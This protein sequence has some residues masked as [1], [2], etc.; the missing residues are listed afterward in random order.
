MNRGLVMIDILSGESSPIGLS[1]YCVIIENLLML[2]QLLL[3]KPI[4]LWK[5][6]DVNSED[7]IRKLKELNIDLFMS[8]AY[9]QTSQKKFLIF[10]K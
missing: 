5:I 6:F 2:K 7:T 4:E 1:A 10:Q 9:P 3:F 8:A